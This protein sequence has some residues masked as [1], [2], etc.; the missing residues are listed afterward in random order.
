MSLNA[1]ANLLTLTSL[2]FGIA[3]LVLFL[4]WGMRQRDDDGTMDTPSPLPTDRPTNA[5]ILGAGWFVF[6]IAGLALRA[7]NT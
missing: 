7:F 3:G 5:L 1:L 6:A 2:A 4:R